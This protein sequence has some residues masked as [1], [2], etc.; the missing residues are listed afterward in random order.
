MLKFLHV[1]LLQ[2]NKYSEGHDSAEVASS[3]ATNEP[4]STNH[5]SLTKSTSRFIRLPIV[6]RQQ[7]RSLWSLRDTIGNR[8]LPIADGFNININHEQE[9]KTVITSICGVYSCC[10]KLLQEAVASLN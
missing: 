3:K 7:F 8:R 9:E 2:K 6:L 4:F 1:F 5:A 10:S